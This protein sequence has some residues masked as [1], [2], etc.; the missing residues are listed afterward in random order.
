MFEHVRSQHI[1]ADS[2]EVEIMYIDIWH[3]Y[4]KIIPC[5]LNYTQDESCAAFPV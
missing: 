2:V 4:Q 5:V 3:D 1:P